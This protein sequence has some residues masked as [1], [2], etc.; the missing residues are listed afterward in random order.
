MRLRRQSA[1]RAGLQFRQIVAGHILDDAGARLEDFAPVGDP[2]ETQ[3]MIAHRAHFN[4]AGSGK[5]AGDEA[6]NRSGV[7]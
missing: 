1:V 5:I 4:A 6:A 2:G 3:H 7:R